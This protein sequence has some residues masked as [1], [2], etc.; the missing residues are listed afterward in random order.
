MNKEPRYRDQRSDVCYAD[1][2]I[3][4][5]PIDIKSAI[6]ISLWLTQFISN[7]IVL[8]REIAI[9]RKAL[10]M[11]SKI[12]KSAAKYRDLQK[13]AWCIDIVI[14]DINIKWVILIDLYTRSQ[15]KNDQPGW[16]DFRL[17]SPTIFN[18]FP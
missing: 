15:I 18:R 2:V 11:Y 10:Q 3:F 4:D 16:H 13:D 9:N 14:I 1:I 8:E 17:T 6:F 12:K 5:W 7:C